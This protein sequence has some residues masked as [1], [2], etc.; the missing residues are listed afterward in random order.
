MKKAFTLLGAAMFFVA[1]VVAGCGKKVNTAGK[2]EKADGETKQIVVK[3]EDKSETL[4]LKADT[5]IT[6]KD[7]KEVKIADLVGK[8]VKVVS[9]HKKVDSISGT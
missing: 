5:K 6:D 8:S 4:T 2:L 7:G 9:E 1:A 3:V